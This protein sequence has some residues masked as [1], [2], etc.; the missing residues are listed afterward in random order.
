MAAEEYHYVVVG[1]GSAGCTLAGRLSEQP[2]VSVALVEAGPMDIDPVFRVPARFW[3]QQKSSF[4]WDL[5]TEPEPALC[6]RRSYLPRGRVLGGTSSMNTMLYVRGC[7]ADYD[8]WAAAGHEGW[9]FAEVLPLFMRS[10][11]NSRGGGPY[12]GAGGPLRV[13][14]LQP[15]PLL[16]RWLAAAGEAGHPANADVNG[17]D[18]EG[19]GVYQANQH[20]GVRCSAAAAF[21]HP[22]LHRPNLSVHTCTHALRLVWDGVRVAGVEVEHCG[23]KRV[24]ACARETVLCAGAYL[25]PQLLMLSGIGPAEHLRQMGIEVR[26]DNP[27]VG[28]NLQDHP[29]C[30]LTYPVSAE[31]G[32]SDPDAWVEVGGFAHSR[33]GLRE[34]DLQFH[35]A[36]G[37]FAD[38][39][40]STGAARALSFGPYV[41]RPR[42]R[43]WVRLRSSLPQAKPRILHNFLGEESDVAVLRAGVRMALQIA[44]QPSLSAVLGDSEGARAAGVP[45]GDSDSAI[46]EYMRR[47]TF[48]FYHPAGTCAMGSVVDS[49]MRV[50]GVGGVRVC[51]TS[52]MP[53]L[54]GGN[55][56]A[57]AI[58]FGEKLAGSLT[59][60]S[61][62]GQSGMRPDN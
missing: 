26:I 43:G 2:G 6:G 15:P 59:G 16:E 62:A 33:P 46:D 47:S 39:G 42:S 34:P 35:A 10:E 56:N 44:S 28:A 52:I 9:S 14:D 4:D 27:D 38:E 40:A 19:M 21:I 1:G 31:T 29:G 30:F 11:D 54:V 53:T 48:S 57:P 8:G 55:T 5:Q 18:Q 7:A 12:H 20:G 49:Q 23:E 22:N 51:D 32:G 61:I 24:I 60:G 50:L 37:S 25:S 41:T 13:E 36:V 17:P 45:S 58:M 3:E